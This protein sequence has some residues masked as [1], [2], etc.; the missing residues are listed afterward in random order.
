M[1]PDF[2]TGQEIFNTVHMDTKS[3]MEKWL[4]CNFYFLSL[5]NNFFILYIK[6]KVQVV[7][8]ILHAIYD[9]LLIKKWSSALSFQSGRAHFNANDLLPITQL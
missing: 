6:T 4:V 8:C 1:E 2:V 7:G 3:N 5:T 9:T